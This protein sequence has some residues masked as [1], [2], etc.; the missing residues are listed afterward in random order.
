ML[1]A[2][3]QSYDLVQ[4]SGRLTPQE[5]AAAE[6]QLAICESSDWFWWFGDYNPSQAVAS[7]DKLYRRNLINLYH[8]LKLPPPSQLHLPISHGSHDA[9]GG[10]MRRALEHPQ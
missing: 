7:F 2:A 6:R 9:E 4:S 10:T 3:K 1:C 5:S 8:L